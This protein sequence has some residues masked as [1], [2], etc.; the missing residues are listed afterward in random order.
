VRPGLSVDGHQLVLTN[1]LAVLRKVVGAPTRTNWVAAGATVLYAFDRHGI[2][3]SAL[4]DTQPDCLLLDF[5]GEGGEYGTQT[6]FSG[7]LRIGTQELHPHTP[8]AILSNN[9]QLSFTNALSDGRILEGRCNGFVTI[10]SFL[11]STDC[12]SSVE[13]RF[14]GLI[15]SPPLAK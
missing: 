1:A 10:C 4:R 6:P 11:K 8:A 12:L 7:I 3:L 15:R 9:P 13:I 2:L 5:E 14:P